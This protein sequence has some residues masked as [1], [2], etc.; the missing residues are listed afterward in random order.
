MP[1]IIGCLVVTALLGWF[2]LHQK[3]V[4]PSVAPIVKIDSPP[5]TGVLT[6]PVKIF[7]RAF[8]RSPAPDDRILHA[9][10]RE[11]SDSGGL[12][13]WQWF[14]AVE[15]SPALMKYLRADNAFGLVPFPMKLDLTGPPEWFAF[16][17]AEVDVLAA[18]RGNLRLIFSKTKNQLFAMDS[19][20]GFQ[21]GAT[22][23][24]APSGP[25]VTVSGRLPAVSPPTPSVR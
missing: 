14:I 11:W 4:P 13:R 10:R 19:G 21:P 8:W 15:P 16:S 2:A 17:P 1:G 20:S 9:E 3:A 25:P 24:P 7:Q 5:P 23:A 18:P 22:A 12:K 6:D